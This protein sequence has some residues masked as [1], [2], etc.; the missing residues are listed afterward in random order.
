MEC[1][2]GEAVTFHRFGFR[3]LYADD[4]ALE[5]YPISCRPQNFSLAHSRV[6]CTL[7]HQ[8]QVVRRTTQHTLKRFGGQDVILD[9]L[10][11]AGTHL[12]RTHMRGYWRDL[13]PA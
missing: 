9:V 6:I 13:H 11:L 2:Y 4:P 1:F 5:V 8:L 3:L 10:A 12:A 7:D